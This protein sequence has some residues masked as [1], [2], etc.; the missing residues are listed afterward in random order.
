MSQ[1]DRLYINKAEIEI[2]YHLTPAD[3]VL[4]PSSRGRTTA[5]GMVEFQ[6]RNM[7]D[8]DIEIVFRGAVLLYQAQAG[9]FGECLDTSLIWLFG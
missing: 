5:A 6:R 3:L 7:S 1:A 8:E 9:T 4:D 2:P